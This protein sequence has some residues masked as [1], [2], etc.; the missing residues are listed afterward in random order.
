[1]GL[2]VDG[3]SPTGAVR[4]YER[5]G[6]RVERRFDHYQRPLFEKVG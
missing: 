1:V 6:M 2:G 3:L 5:V 4:L